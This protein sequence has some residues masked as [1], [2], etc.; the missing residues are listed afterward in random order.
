MIVSGD[1]CQ[2]CRPSLDGSFRAACANFV[3]RSR[4]VR[5]RRRC[6][7][8][9]RARRGSRRSSRPIPDRSFSRTRGIAT[10]SRIPP[11][12]RKTRSMDGHAQGPDPQGGGHRETAQ[13]GCPD[14][15]RGLI[16]GGGVG[17]SKQGGAPCQPLSSQPPARRLTNGPPPPDKIW[18]RLAP[19]GNAWAH[20]FSPWPRH[21]LG[22]GSFGGPTCG[23]TPVIEALLRA[24]PRSA[25]P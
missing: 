7:R 14:P 10:S 13:G 3:S 22:L 20:F 11:E 23:G 24:C 1:S 17:R 4:A 21:A 12:R 18:A 6:N 19:G 9:S 15:S 5:S 25:S 2:R 8:R 16:G